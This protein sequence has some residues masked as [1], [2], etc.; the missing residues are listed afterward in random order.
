VVQFDTT[1]QQYKLK[2]AQSDLLE[3]AQKIIQAK[4]KHAAEIEEDRYSLLKARNDLTLA[5]LEARKNR[6]LPAISAKQNDLAVQN[7]RDHLAQVER[8]VANRQATGGAG[9]EIEQAGRAKA[10]SQATT[11]RQNIEAMT[12]RTHHSGYVAIKQNMPTNGF[13]F[14]GMVMPLFQVGD[15]ANPGMAIAE[16]PDLGNWQIAANINEL[17]RGHIAVGNPVD[18]T[19]VAVPQQRFHGAIKDMGGT[20]GPFW[21]RHFESKIALNDPLPALRPGMTATLVITTQTL[22]NVLSIPAQSLFESNGKTSVF[23]R[24]GKTFTSRTVQLVQ[25]NETRAVIEGLQ[26]G[27]SVALANPLEAANNKTRATSPLSTVGK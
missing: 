25:K 15:S 23:L 4:A 17:D 18:I 16:I 2:E 21:D 13:F 1:E 27:D 5:E 11:A 20:T 3:A 10:E 12:L 8:N 22:K 24:S 14:D 7:A 26:E 6:L 9:I 19:V